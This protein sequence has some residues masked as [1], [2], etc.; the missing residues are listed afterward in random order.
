[1]EVRLFGEES[2][3]ESL[4]LADDKILESVHGGYLRKIDTPESAMMVCES[5]NDR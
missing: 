5:K 4:K 1:M 2:R 3:P